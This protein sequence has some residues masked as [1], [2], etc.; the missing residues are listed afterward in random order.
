MHRPHPNLAGVRQEGEGWVGWPSP[1][2]LPFSVAFGTQAVSTTHA[3]VTS[4]YSTSL[5]LCASLVIDLA[6]T[7]RR[8]WLYIWNGTFNPLF[9]NFLQLWCHLLQHH[10]Y[11]ALILRPEDEITTLRNNTH[12]TEN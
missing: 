8:Y 12:L 7:S 9:T 3:C 10:V 1:P 2:I 11:K 4:C 6:D 5:S